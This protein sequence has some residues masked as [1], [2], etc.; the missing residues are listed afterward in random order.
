MLCRHTLP[1]AS[2]DACTPKR[3]IRQRPC[4]Q[5]HRMGGPENTRNKTAVKASL[6]PG[7]T[8]RSVSSRWKAQRQRSKATAR[9][10]PSCGITAAAGGQ[11]REPFLLCDAL[12]SCAVPLGHKLSTHATSSGSSCCPPLTSLAGQQVQGLCLLWRLILPT[13]PPCSRNRHGKKGRGR[14]HHD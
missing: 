6:P 14:I 4:I 10:V 7:P 12:E 9:Q 1:Y 3:G 8:L 5:Q 13:R 2:S 11:G